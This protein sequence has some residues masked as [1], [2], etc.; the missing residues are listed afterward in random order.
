MMARLTKPTAQCGFQPVLKTFAILL[1]TFQE[2]RLLT[3]TLE[4]NYLR[5]SHGQ[6]LKSN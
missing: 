4:M 3:Y 5:H 1:A 6:H 2:F